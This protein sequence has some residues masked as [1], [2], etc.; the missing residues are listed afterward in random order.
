MRLDIS[1]RMARAMA[2]QPAQ[3]LLGDLGVAHDRD[4]EDPGVAQ[5][6]RHPH[7]RD[8][9]RHRFALV[10]LAQDAAELALHELIE[11][12]GAVGHGSP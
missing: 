1:S 10:A 3:F 6:G 9:H 7:L 12:D 5:V 4:K 11:A 2:A 8:R